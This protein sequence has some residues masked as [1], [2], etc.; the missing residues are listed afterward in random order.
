[1]ATAI[2]D[3]GEVVGG[4]D[5]TDFSVGTAETFRWSE[6]TG[7]QIITPLADRIGDYAKLFDINNSGVAVGYRHSVPG[8]TF[9]TDTTYL[10]LAQPPGCPELYDIALAMNDAGTIVGGRQ[11]GETLPVPF[12]AEMASAIN[13]SGQIAG[14]GSDG[15]SSKAWFLDGRAFEWIALPDEGTEVQVMDLSDDGCRV[16]PLPG[17]QPSVLLRTLPL[18]ARNVHDDS[19]ACAVRFRASDCSS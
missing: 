12:G 17:E 18:A 10:P 19:T 5:V 16:R 1:V 7:T 8:A 9:V 4:I 11:F 3:L 2:N 6:R 15:I 13:A 14:Q